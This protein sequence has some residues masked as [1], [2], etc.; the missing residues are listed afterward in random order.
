M[1]GHFA[2]R[3]LKRIKGLL[4]IVVCEITVSDLVPRI[5]VSGIEIESVFDIFKRLWVQHA[6]GVATTMW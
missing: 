2:E 5:A 4:E 1:I 6:R 3:V